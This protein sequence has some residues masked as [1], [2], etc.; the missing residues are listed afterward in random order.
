MFDEIQASAL[1]YR[2]DIDKLTELIFLMTVLPKKKPP[3]KVNCAIVFS[4]MAAAVS[5]ITG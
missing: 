3:K 4:Y 1:E 5:L 2:D